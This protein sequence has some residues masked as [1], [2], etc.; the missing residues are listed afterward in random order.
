[1]ATFVY[2]NK[3]ISWLLN[4]KQMKGSKNESTI[5]KTKV[6]FTEKKILYFKESIIFQSNHCKLKNYIKQEVLSLCNKVL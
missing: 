4:P 6:L 3:H 2:S 1:M 5:T